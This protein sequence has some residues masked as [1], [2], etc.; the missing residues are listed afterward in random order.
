MNLDS[1]YS[2]LTL[3]GTKAKLVLLVL[4]GLGDIAT[5]ENG[6]ITPLEAAA[7]PGEWRAGTVDTDCIF[8]PSTHPDRISFEHVALRM[9]KHF[10]T[11]EAD[12]R[13][14]AAMRNAFPA[15]L[16]AARAALTATAEPT[17]GEER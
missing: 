5:R 14:I 9:N 15:L 3:K 2:E 13:L 16:K 12:A 1:V 6:Y 11:H 7:T 8:V 4:D 10:D 17:A